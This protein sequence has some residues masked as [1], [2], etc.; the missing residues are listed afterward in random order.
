MK[1]ISLEK[2][3]VYKKELLIEKEIIK[4]DDFKLSIENLLRRFFFETNDA[5]TRNQI[6]TLISALIEQRSPHARYLVVCDETNNQPDHIDAGILVV[7]IYIQGNYNISAV[8]RNEG[9]LHDV[10][11]FF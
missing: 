10:N 7:D 9:D 8:I 1:Y 11:R 2:R 3:F 6:I 4:V 5:I